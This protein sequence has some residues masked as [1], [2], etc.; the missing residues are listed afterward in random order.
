MSKRDNRK[1]KNYKIMFIYSMVLD[2]FFFIPNKY[3][4]NLYSKQRVVTRAIYNIN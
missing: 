4:E 1:A 3:G 2:A